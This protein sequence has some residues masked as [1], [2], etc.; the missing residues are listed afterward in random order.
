[1]LSFFTPITMVL[2]VHNTLFWGYYE[3]GSIRKNMGHPPKITKTSQKCHMTK[4][5][6]ACNLW[7]DP[8]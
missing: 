8:Q 7:D 1:M 2:Q 4:A 6:V 3:E 5:T